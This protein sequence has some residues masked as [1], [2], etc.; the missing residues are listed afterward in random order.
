M[1]E[2]QSSKAI[3]TLTSWQLLAANVSVECDDKQEEQANFNFDEC[4]G[5]NDEAMQEAFG[6]SGGKDVLLSC[7]RSPSFFAQPATLE[8]AKKL[9][10]TPKQHHLLYRE[11]RILNEIGSGAFGR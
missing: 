8:D 7:L 1:E 2:L 6:V 5:P 11:Y 9:N 10:V 4:A 3:G